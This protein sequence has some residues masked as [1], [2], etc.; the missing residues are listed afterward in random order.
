MAA[1]WAALSVQLHVQPHPQAFPSVTSAAVA[2]PPRSVIYH[3][4][5]AVCQQQHHVTSKPQEH[6][7]LWGIAHLCAS[8]TSALAQS[9]GICVLP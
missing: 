9:R 3:L 1:A 5:R 6:S 2:V 8:V 4:C 7:H